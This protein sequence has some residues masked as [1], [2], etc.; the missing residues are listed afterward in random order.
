MPAPEKKRKHSA[1]PSAR[2]SR[3]GRLTDVSDVP[4][5]SSQKCVC[6][7]V[8]TYESNAD[9][10][11]TNMLNKSHL[12]VDLAYIPPLADEP[13]NHLGLHPSVYRFAQKHLAEDP[14]DKKHLRIIKKYCQISSEPRIVFRNNDAK[15]LPVAFCHIVGTQLKADGYFCQTSIHEKEGWLEQLRDCVSHRCKVCR[16]GEGNEDLAKRL[17]QQWSD[18]Q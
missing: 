8:G 12:D 5:D 15:L 2:A 9:D 18:L 7:F 10:G 16:P 17:Q 6:L 3:S 13:V 1:G 4:A 11:S 14:D